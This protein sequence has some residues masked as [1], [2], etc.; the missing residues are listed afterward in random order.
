MGKKWIRNLIKLIW[1][2][3]SVAVLLLAMA[4]CSKGIQEEEQDDWKKVSDISVMTQ[5][6]RDAAGNE[7]VYHCCRKIS[8]TD[9]SGRDMTEM[10]VTDNGID[11]RTLSAVIDWDG[12]TDRRDDMVGQW[13]AMWCQAYGSSYLCWTISPEYSCVIVYDGDVVAEEDVFRMA[14]SVVQKQ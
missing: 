7:I 13:P 9:G 12:V 2:M 3:I 8:H 1:C 10:G 14:E 4:G 6:Y 5:R 11:S